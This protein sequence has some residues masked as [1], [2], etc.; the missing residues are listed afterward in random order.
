VTNKPFES[1]KM[2]IKLLL[3]LLTICISNAAIGQ[4]KKKMLT[5]KEKIELL[6]AS[7]ENL[8]NAKFYRNGTLYDAKSAAEHLRMKLGKAGDRVKTAQDFIEVIASK[9]S[10]TGENYKIVFTD[11]KEINTSKFLYDKLESIN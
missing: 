1:F 10:M 7:I 3:V 6:I 5:E 4:T 8:E 11:G 9:S 2:R